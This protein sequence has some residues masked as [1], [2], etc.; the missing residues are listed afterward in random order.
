MAEGALHA[1]NLALQGRLVFSDAG[2]F[3]SHILNR[4]QCEYGYA[5]SFLAANVADLYDE[6]L[7][8]A[9]PILPSS[10][11]TRDDQRSKF[12]GATGVAVP[13][14]VEPIHPLHPDAA[15]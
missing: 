11:E 6:L 9:T 7:S 3:G 4:S 2:A 15:G 13:P 5:I 14:V 1:K 10:Q 12:S 8:L